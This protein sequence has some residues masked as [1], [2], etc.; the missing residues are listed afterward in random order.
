MTAILYNNKSDNREVNKNI[1]EIYTIDVTLYMDTNLLK[2]VFR[3]KT[4]NNNA[5]YIYVPNLGRYYYIDNYILSNQCVYLHCSVDVLMSY[6][7]ELLNT[8][9]LISRSETDYNDNIVDTLAPITEDTVYT[10]K[11]FGE[12][13]K[14]TEHYILGVI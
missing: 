13:I 1:T 6:K 12:N 8:E 9:C 4:F 3:V 10:V 5:N 14:S 7:T 11:N 2:P